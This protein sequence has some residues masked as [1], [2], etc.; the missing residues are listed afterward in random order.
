MADFGNLDNF[1]ARTADFF[2]VPKIMAI[3]FVKAMACKW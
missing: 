1:T 3:F 2:E